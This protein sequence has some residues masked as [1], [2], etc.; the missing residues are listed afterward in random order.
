[1]SF[2]ALVF[3]FKVLVTGLMVGAPFLFL[4]AARV[5]MS[6]GY[7]EAAAPLFRLYGVAIFALLFGYGY[8]YWLLGQGIFPWGIIAMGLLSNGGGAAVLF[9]SGAWRRSKTIAYFI[10]AVAVALA[11]A[12][13]AP[14]WAVTP[15]W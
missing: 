8:G 13:L 11:A 7:G 3:I 10:S 9:A 6:T 12:A 15:I 5:D 4:P 1:M 2:L 14:E